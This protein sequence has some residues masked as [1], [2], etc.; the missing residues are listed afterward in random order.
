MFSLCANLYLCL[1]ISGIKGCIPT[2]ECERLIFTDFFQLIFTFNY[3]IHSYITHSSEVFHIPKRNTMQLVL[4]LLSF[5]G[6]EV[7][8]KFYFKI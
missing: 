1:I 6:A 2:A 7:W 8:N 3:D 4:I 5:D